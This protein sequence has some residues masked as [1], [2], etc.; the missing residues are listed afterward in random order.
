MLAI[1]DPARSFGITYESLIV[2]FLLGLGIPSEDEFREK[3]GSFSSIIDLSRA[4]SS[5]FRPQMFA[6][7]ASGSPFVKPQGDV[8]TVLFYYFLWFSV[9]TD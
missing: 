1:G 9:N 7:A 4:G 5:E 3:Q 6:W 2:E 8:F